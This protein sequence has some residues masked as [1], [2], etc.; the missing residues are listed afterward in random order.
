MKPANYRC[1]F[2]NTLAVHLNQHH[3]EAVVRP[4]PGKIIFL[5]GLASPPPGLILKMSFLGENR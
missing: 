2:F 1:M 5:E 4:N 3:I